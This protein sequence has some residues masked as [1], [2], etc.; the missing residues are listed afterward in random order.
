[1]SDTPS[2]KKAHVDL[3]LGEQVSFREKSNGLEGWEF[4][5]N[6]LPE[7][8]TEDIDTSCTFLGARIS[9]PLMITGM[10]GGYQD[11]ERINGAL[12]EACQD[13]RIPIG[14]GSMRQALENETFHES[15]RV[16]RRNGPDIPILANIGAVEVAAMRDV[17]PAAW[18]VDLIEADALVVHTNPLQEFLQP[19]GEPRFRGVL[20]GLEMLVRELDVPVILKEVGAGISREATMRAY[21]AGVQW[22]DISGAGGTSWA[23][24]EMLRRSDGCEVSP[25]FWDWGISTASALE[26]LRFN[27]PTDLHVIASGGISDGVM[28]AKC[29]ALGAE[30][31]GA[32]RPMLTAFFDGGTDALRNRLCGWKRDLLGV[33]FLTGA[34]DIDALRCKP[35]DMIRAH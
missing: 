11:A 20:N 35:I 2:R 31:A 30:L 14:A 1:M 8:N 22:I 15:Y 3:C 26:E 6:A 10:T 13:L 4:A 12:A 24:V 33:M 9:F 21:D 17:R 34:A 28:I 18:L 32:A 29:L 16:L 5:H 7:L 19:E 23:G 27:R 25:A